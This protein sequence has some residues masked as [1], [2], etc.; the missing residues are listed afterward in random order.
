MNTTEI[1]PSFWWETLIKAQENSLE[2]E[3]I[4]VLLLN[5][6]AS[7]TTIEDENEIK[8]YI[9]GTEQDAMD[10]YKAAQEKHIVLSR[11]T[12]VT[13]KNWVAECSEVLERVNTPHWCIIPVIDESETPELDYSMLS[14]EQRPI[15]IL[16]GAGFGTGHHESTRLA[17]E[18]LVHPRCQLT[19]PER[20]LDFGTGNGILA[21]AC[22]ILFPHSKVDATDK[23]KQSLVNAAQNA[24]LNDIVQRDIEWIRG[25]IPDNSQHYSL[26][27]ANIY[28][29]VLVEYEPRLRDRV[30]DG[31][32]CILSGILTDKCTLVK[33]A[34]L[35]HWELLSETHEGRSWSS[36]LLQ[37]RGQ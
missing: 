33:E 18:H 6:G 29:E 9:E 22:A 35:P 14:A 11:P 20:I 31:A 7:G 21:I 26:I 32:L 27:C 5:A 15:V 37:C 36:L 8:C 16:P 2:L 34:F 13:E 4:G 12:K 30:K 25:D 1:E 23:D 3:A 10:L 24:Q 19:N 17:L 28:A